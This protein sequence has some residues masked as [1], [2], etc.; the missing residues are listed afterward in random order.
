MAPFS[1]IRQ[2]KKL[3]IAGQPVPPIAK[4]V[5]AEFWAALVLSWCGAHLGREL[6]SWFV[7][8][9]ACAGGHPSLPSA[10]V[11]S[12]CGQQLSA[13]FLKLWITTPVWGT[14]SWGCRGFV[15]ARGQL[16]AVVWF[17]YLPSLANGLVCVTDHQRGK[18]RVFSWLLP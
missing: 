4:I 3:V 8:T 18:T 2:P 13:W 17:R 6:S 9:Q 7:V 10:A 14:F 12:S 15:L 16:S 11:A 5:D 1:C